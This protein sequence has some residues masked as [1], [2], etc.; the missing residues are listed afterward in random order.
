M[1]DVSE[2]VVCAVAALG[3]ACERLTSLHYVTAFL[4]LKKRSGSQNSPTD[5]RAL[6]KENL[7]HSRAFGKGKEALRSRRKP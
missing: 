6:K 5:T 2:G 1:S 7:G 3:A 4:F